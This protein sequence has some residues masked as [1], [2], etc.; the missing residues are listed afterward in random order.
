MLELGGQ[1]KEAGRFNVAFLAYFL[2]GQ[3]E[4]AIQLLIDANRIPE[5]AFMART[6]MPS[7]ISR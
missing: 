4:E 7:Q 2:T 1:A 5:A 3:V 6:Y